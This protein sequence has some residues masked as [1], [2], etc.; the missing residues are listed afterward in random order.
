MCMGRG[1][2]FFF[3]FFFFWGGGG[4]KRRVADYQ[5]DYYYCYHA[6]YTLV[7]EQLEINSIKHKSNP[8]KKVKFVLP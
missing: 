2:V 8:K 3:F 6:A 5:G 7:G 1:E 4:G